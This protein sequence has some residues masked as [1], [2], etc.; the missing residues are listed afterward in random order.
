[1][2][3]I[4]LIEKQMTAT[5]IDG[6]VGTRSDASGALSLYAPTMLIG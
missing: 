3:P 2:Y 5:Q 4:G 6:M 1:M